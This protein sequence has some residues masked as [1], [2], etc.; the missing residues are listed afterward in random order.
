MPREGN[1]S[2]AVVLEQRDEA[3]R[4]LKQERAR[5][6]KLEAQ[7]AWLTKQMFGRR[8]ERR[9]DSLTGN[10]FPP[11][12]A[13]A[14]ADTSESEEESVAPKRTRASRRV[15]GRRKIPDDL[16]R[17][18]TEIMPPE[19]ECRC[20]RCEVQKQ[21]IGREITE[22]LEYQPGSLFVLREERVKL[23][24][25]TCQQGVAC[26]PLPARPI[27]RGLPGPGLLAFVLTSKYGD[28]STLYR[29]EQILERHGLAVSRSTMCGWVA[30]VATLL[31]PIVQEMKRQV[32]AC[33]YVRSDDTSVR[34]LGTPSEGG[35]SSKSY[36]WLYRG[37]RGL[38]L[39]EFRRGRSRD[40]PSG[41]LAD[42]EGYLQVDGYSGYDELIAKSN[43]RIIRVACWAHVRRYFIKAEKSDPELAV[44]MLGMIRALYAIEREA[45]RKDLEPPERLAL[46]KERACPILVRIGEWLESNKDSVLPSSPM[47]EAVTY[48]LGQWDALRR[49]AEDGILEIDNNF[50]EQAVRP[51]AL[52]RKNWLFFA[53][54]AGGHRAATIFSLV[55]SCKELGIDPFAYLK[56]VL[57]VVSTTPQSRV[58]DLT[59][60]GWLESRRQPSED[61]PAELSRHA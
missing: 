40:G 26:A 43:G 51:V 3:L 46:R 17:Q 19:D 10:L 6:Q 14:D 7:V 50:T 59:P 54:E 29:L 32:I 12:P 13:E 23:S 49:Y 58:H 31:D 8:S 30:A 22:R 24:C 38:V 11:P 60:L 61:A 4:L 33:G 37:G 15:G 53:R 45:R 55:H 28:H 9:T 57:D 41:F 48:T 2:I 39:Y 1:E 5:I 16:P 52:G 47:G 34:L 27:D 44:Q 35:G 36:V 25:P 18:V 21:E 42:F 20:A 56:D